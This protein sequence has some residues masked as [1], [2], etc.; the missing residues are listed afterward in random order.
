MKQIVLILICLLNIQYSKAQEE[1]IV[2]TVTHKVQLGETMV[3]I[4][5]NYLATP[6]EIY[7]LN[8]QAVNGISEGMIL[9]IPVTPEYKSKQEKVREFNAKKSVESKSNAKVIS[10]QVI[11]G[12]NLYNISKKY[13]T[14]KEKI[15]QDNAELLKNGLQVDQVL[16]ISIPNDFVSM[17]K[18]TKVISAIS[19]ETNSSSETTHFVQQ[20]ET[21]YSISKKYNI[22]EED[23]KKLNEDLLIE[24]LKAGQTVKIKS[25]GTIL[26]SSKSNVNN[27]STLKHKVAAKETLY[28]IS[29]IYKLTIQ[30][31]IDTNP[32]LKDRGAQEGEDLIIK[33]KNQ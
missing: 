3:M 5:K 8:K 7:K 11:K 32:Q 12:D 16:K 29:K 26:D 2:E 1:K 27:G 22:S 21:I 31:I 13:N 18:E 25:T 15:E 4:S 14:T 6:T 30:D 28:S 33:I 24:G 23:F 19:T 20:G 10:H 17:S 9:E